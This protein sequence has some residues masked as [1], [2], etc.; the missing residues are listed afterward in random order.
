MPTKKW[1]ES[2][3]KECKEKG[4]RTTPVFK[5][6]NT[7]PFKDGQDYKNIDDYRGCA[8][9]GLILDNVILLDYDGNKSDD[10]MTI[11]DL[12]ETL[13]EFEMPEPAQQKDQSIHWLYALPE[14]DFSASADGYWPYIDIKCQNQLMHLKD[15]KTLNLPNKKD[16]EPAAKA[17]L[18]ALK[19]E[20]KKPRQAPNEDLGDFAGLI[21]ESTTPKEKVEAWLSKIS[22]DIGGH[23]WVQVGNALHDWD[24]VLGLDLWTEWSRGSDKFKPGEC[25]NRWARFQKGK[26]I[27]LGTLVHKAKESD[28]EQ[29][30]NEIEKLTA[31]IKNADRKEIE[32]SIVKQIK[33]LELN[34]IDREILVTALQSRIKELTGAKPKVA[35]VRDMIRHTIT[36]ELVDGGKPSWCNDWIYINDINRFANTQTRV[37]YKHEAF[38]LL[39]G[40]NV[41]LSESG[42]KPTASK[43]MAD[44]GYVD[45]V[46]SSGFYPFCDDAVYKTRDGKVFNTFNPKHVPETAKA[47]TEEGLK[48][49]ELVR[50]HTEFVCGTPEN[51]EILIQWLAHNVQFMGTKL[52]WAP[53]IQSIEGAGKSFYKHLLY[54]VIGEKQ[55]G[56]ISPSNAVS[57]FNAWATGHVVNILEEI[58]I[59][60]HNRYEA[61]NALKP[62]ITDS[63][64]DINPK[65]TPQ[66]NTHNTANYLALT[67]FKDALPLVSSDRRWWVIFAQIESLDEVESIVGIEKNEYFNSIYDAVRNNGA[68]L[69]KWLLE[70]PISEKFKAMKQAPMTV[71]KEMMISTEESNFEYLDEVKQLIKDGGKYFKEGCI[72]SSDLFEELMFQ[73]TY[74]LS[75]KDKNMLLKKLGYSK[76]P[77]L[78]K[79]DNKPRSVWT[80]KALTPEQIRD[81][82]AKGEG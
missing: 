14:G 79:I 45:V 15:S 23:E 69:R 60:G 52:L 41:P 16:L 25:E 40:I 10:I 74:V 35:S 71:H 6:G 48:A 32:L 82:F 72:S 80:K 70:Y 12:A 9:I 31:K 57:T 28:F 17:I 29:Q 65:G 76:H 7:K 11:D 5:E 77:K 2:T 22:P 26:G 63:V 27:T 68:E 81:I 33:K 13:G 61:L 62:L 39:N 20:N 50:K 73:H 30:E 8:H 42:G 36:G 1:I 66:Y 56:T 58:K 21:P 38:N 49:I 53:L 51:A 34:E 43:F 44:N 47:F 3:L 67:N 78:I 55:V 4:Y 24:S 54:E 37:L 64:I 46:T 19:L 59:Q 18:N 75:N